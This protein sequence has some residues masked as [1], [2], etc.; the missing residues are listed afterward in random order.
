MLPVAEYEILPADT[1]VV[2]GHRSCLRDEG[3][4][5]Q[6]KMFMVMFLTVG[7]TTLIVIGAATGWSYLR[8]G[9]AAADHDPA[10]ELARAG[11]VKTEIAALEAPVPDVADDARREAE[12]LT[13]V[14]LHAGTLQCVASDFNLGL[15]TF[16]GSAHADTDAVPDVGLLNWEPLAAGMSASA[17]VPEPMTLSLLLIGSAAALLH[18]GR[19]GA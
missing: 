2:S 14:G 16:D 17:A 9:H 13:F 3:E 7:I 10:L 6:M 18:R 1:E 4:E 8:A 19:H 5:N 15:S 12:P 11:D